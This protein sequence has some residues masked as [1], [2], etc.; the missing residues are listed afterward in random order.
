MRKSLYKYMCSFSMLTLV[1]LF[2]QDLS[3]KDVVITDFG[4]VA[5]STTLNT[6]AIQKAIDTCAE[7]GGGRVTIPSGIFLTG[8]INLRSHVE[9]YLNRGAVIRGSLRIPEDYPQRALIYAENIEDAGISGDGII[10]GYSNHP[11]YKERFRVNDGKR[12]R[13]IFFNHCKKMSLRDIQIRNAGSWTVRLLGC[14]GV[15]IDGISIY[16]LTQGN[17]DCIDV[18]ARNVTISNCNI[19]C[20]DDGICLKSDLPDF[21]PE[22]ITVTNCVIASNCNPIKLGTSSYSGFRNVVFSNCVV[23]RTEESVIWDWAKEYRKVAPDTHTGLSGITV[24]CVDGGTIENIS[25]NNIVLEGIITPIFVCL[26]HRHGNEGT[27]RNLQFSNITAKADGIIPC[28]ISGVPDARIE[29]ITLRDIIVE[30]E[31]GEEAMIERLPENLKGYPENRMYGRRNPAGGLYIRHADNI[32]VENFQVRQ[33]NADY[34]PAVVLDYV[35]DFRIR[36]LKAIVTKAYE[37]VQ[38][39]DCKNIKIMDN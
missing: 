10:D 7:T 5:D 3:A 32:L 19:S 25:F 34:R 30:H 28:L 37:L 29:G 22:N 6:T 18:D 12:P 23:R 9:I 16:C 36:G 15:N 26:N 35:A 24:Q 27:I 38:T 2:A 11:S 39:I 20:D 4:A 8:A 17:N 14:D 21:L 13:G 33:R 1:I 31:G